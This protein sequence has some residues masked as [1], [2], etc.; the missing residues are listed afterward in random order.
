MELDKGTLAL[1]VDKSPSVNTETLHHS[2]R[3][4]DC[5]IG[6]DPHRHCSRLR[7]ETHPVPGIVVSGLRLRDF[8]VRF[9]LEGVDKIGE[10][11]RVLDEE[12]G[13]V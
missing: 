6:E 9:G 8:V 7:A 1:G 10:L 3:S 2:E 11:D 4:R 5:T 12:D 13:D